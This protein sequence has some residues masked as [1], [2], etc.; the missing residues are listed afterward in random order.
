MEEL[1]NPEI[2]T[3]RFTDLLEIEIESLEMESYIATRTIIEKYNDD[4]V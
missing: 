4:W 1:C 2:T 3:E